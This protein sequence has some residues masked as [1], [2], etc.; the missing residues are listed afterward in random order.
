MKRPGDASAPAPA[1]GGPKTSTWD[2][3]LQKAWAIFKENTTVA[4]ERTVENFVSIL[5]KGVRNNKA[6][7]SVASAPTKGKKLHNDAGF[8]KNQKRKAIADTEEEKIDPSE[9]APK[10]KAK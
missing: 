8:Q 1:D 10:K 3:M 6:D 2:Q 4:S 5:P 9:G 7:D